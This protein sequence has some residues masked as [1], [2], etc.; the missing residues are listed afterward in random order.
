MIVPL[1]RSGWRLETLRPTMA[2][3][4]IASLLGATLLV[5]QPASRGFAQGPGPTILIQPSSSD[6]NVGNTV[7]VDIRIENVPEGDDGLYGVDLRLSFN[8]ALLE[9]QD[10]DPGTAEVQIQKGAFPSPDFVV[11]NEADNS[12][13]TIWY[14]VS[15]RKDL[16]PDPVSGSGIVASVTFK[17]LAIGTSPVAFTYQ[18]IVKKDGEQILATTQDGQ[19]MVVATIGH[20]GVT[21]VSATYDGG[22]GQTTF[23]YR[24][25]SEGG[26]GQ[27]GLSYWVIGLCK[28]PVYP[29]SSAYD[30]YVDGSASGYGINAD[31]S[32]ASRVGVQYCEVTTVDPDPSCQASF[33][34]TGI[35]FGNARTGGC[36]TGAEDLL[37]EGREVACDEFTFKLSG[38]WTG[39][40]IGD[41]D[42][43][44]QAPDC[45]YG[46][47]TG[48]FVPGPDCQAGPTGI[49][50]SSFTA[51]SSAGLEASLV[52]P[53][54]VGVATLAMGGVL[55][56]SRRS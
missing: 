40:A 20:Y 26:L 15:Q 7:T 56:I 21:F 1:D 35:K 34:I 23:V 5:S 22:A 37:G 4:I 51:K 12:A 10:A 36:D 30:R 24:V 42:F 29:Q 19:I 32:Y 54:L 39:N 16:H 11:H 43:S 50:L 33:E 53:W 25:C 44:V 2:L 8:P 41:T 52:W 31:G 46:P 6:V 13:G 27:Q 28:N 3:M 14:A 9:V 18:K 45:A 17:G 38:N 48:Q 49:T 47:D 55:W